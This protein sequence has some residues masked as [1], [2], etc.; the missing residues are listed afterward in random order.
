MNDTTD[1]GNKD[2]QEENKQDVVPIV[3]KRGRG[4]P[5][6]IR[7]TVEELLLEASERLQ[8]PVGGVS[9]PSIASKTPEK[10]PQSVEEVPAD[11]QLAYETI[12]RSL[13]VIASRRANRDFLTYIRMMAPKVVDGFKMGRHIEVI[14][15]K[16]Q[17]VVDGKIKRLMVFLPPRSSKSVICSKL[18]PSWYIGRNPKHEIM[19]ISHSDQ[20][21]SDFGRSVRDIVDM[22]EFTTVFNGVQLRQ[23]VRASGKWMTNKN[24]SYYAAGVRS[25][26]AGR[27]AHIAILDDAMSEEDAI[28]SA[29]R[30]YIKEWWP[31]GLRTRLM[32]NGSII[33]INT[34]YHH[35]DLC[36]WLL[37]QEEKMDIPFSKRWDVI[38][39]PA[40]LDRHSAKLLDLPEGSSYF[41]E[42]K[43]DEVL[44]LDEQEIRATN[45]SRYWE[46]LYM[47]NPMPD[48]GGIIKKNWVTWWEGHEPPRCDFI[49]QTYDTAF[50]TRTTADYSVIQ[51]WGIFNNIDTN[52]LNGVETVTSNLIL[53]GNMKGRYEYPE[54]R[55]IAAQEYRK[56]RPD[57]C[58]VEKKASGQSLIQDMRKSGLPVLEYTPDKDKVSRVYSA[59]PM[60]ESRRVWLPKDRSWS[61]DLFDELIGFPY[62]QHDDQVDACIMAVHYVKES[63]RLLHPEDKKWLDDEDRRKTKRVAY[64]RV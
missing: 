43:S 32:P 36:G 12:Q 20:L 19:T 1:G 23:D 37:R 4:R 47:Q 50:S 40:W 60:F 58:I 2:N 39:I 15:Q 9:A 51:T 14:A 35:D 54:L 25:Q 63:W 57:I 16:L 7:K 28:S 61:N 64:W 56:H 44:A 24:G 8:R 42:W 55:R 21:A 26:I 27:G 6:K 62:A 17:M 3:P 34:R 45:G 33:I 11:I 10:A 46:S 48:E 38:R 30:K 52:E 59:S 22:P 53:L 13:R 49:I 18:F 5:K 29:G 31:S 41:P